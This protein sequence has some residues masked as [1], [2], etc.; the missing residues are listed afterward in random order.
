MKLHSFSP[1]GRWKSGQFFNSS[2]PRFKL[3]K[4]KQ[5]TVKGA[6]KMVSVLCKEKFCVCFLPSATLANALSVRIS[7]VLQAATLSCSEQRAKVQNS[8]GGCLA[9]PSLAGGLRR[10][11]VPST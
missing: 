1:E 9:F 11:A 10:S 8:P 2:L 4:E 3:V 5:G 7:Q 6:T